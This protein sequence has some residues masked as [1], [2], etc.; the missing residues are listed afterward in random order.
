MNPEDLKIGDLVRVVKDDYIISK[1]T[2]CKVIGLNT[3]DLSAF[4]GHK[5]TVSL[6]T[7]NK[8]KDIELIKEVKHSLFLIESMLYIRDEDTLV[9]KMDLNI[10]KCDKAL[11]EL[12]D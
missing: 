8:E 4:G 11:K 9:E 1:G 12:E 3:T 2:I 7:V 10:Q 6:S 5:P